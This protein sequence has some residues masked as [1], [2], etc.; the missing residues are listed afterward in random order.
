MAGRF[1]T[2]GFGVGWGIMTTGLFGFACHG[3]ELGVRPFGS[4]MGER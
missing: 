2:F 1:E 3:C 4:G